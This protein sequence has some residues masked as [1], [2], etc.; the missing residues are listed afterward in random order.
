MFGKCKMITYPSLIFCIKVKKDTYFVILTK[1]SG[2]GLGFSIAGGVDLEQK[3]ITVSCCFFLK[4]N[5]QFLF[6]IE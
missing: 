6:L 1:E 3:S 4:E 5:S 2:S